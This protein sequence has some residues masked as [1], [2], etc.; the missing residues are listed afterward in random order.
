MNFIDIFKEEGLYVAKNIR[1][2]VALQIKTDIKGDSALTIVK[3][4]S[5]KTVTP[6]IID[7]AIDKDVVNEVYVKISIKDELFGETR[8]NLFQ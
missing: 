8:K 6:Q 2:G 1:D 5:I 3:Y 4:E 7:R